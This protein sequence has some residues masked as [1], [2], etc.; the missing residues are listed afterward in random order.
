M[1]QIPLEDRIEGGRDLRSTYVF[2]YTAYIAVTHTGS[3]TL[4]LTIREGR[5][6]VTAA[7]T[8]N[9]A[10]V[11]STAKTASL[12]CTGVVDTAIHAHLN[13]ATETQTITAITRGATIATAKT[14]LAETALLAETT[15]IGTRSDPV[16][17]LRLMTVVAT[18]DATVTMTAARTDPTAAP[19]E[20]IIGTV[21]AVL[22]TA[23]RKLTRRL[24]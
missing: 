11:Q 9:L 23:T 20:T 5:R 16:G 10:G 17:L 21:V 14:G 15:T 4:D 6:T 3:P 22:F 19:A 13:H 1:L 2:V 8:R 12:T 7:V 24:S 18:I